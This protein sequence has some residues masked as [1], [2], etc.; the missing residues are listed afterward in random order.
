[1]IIELTGIPGAGKSTVLKSLKNLRDSEGFIFDIQNYILSRTF[2]PFHGKIGYEFVL[3]TKI[4]LLKSEDWLLLKYVFLLIKNS[5]N[6]FFHKVN[7]VRNTMKKLIIYRYIKDSNTVFFI[8]EGVSHIPFTVFVDIYKSMN[9]EKLKVLLELLPSVDFLLIIDAPDAI[10][11]ERVIERGKEGHRRIDFNSKE[12]VE[13]FMQQSR[14][15][16]ELLKMHFSGY[17]YYNIEKEIDREE[18][19]NQLGLKNV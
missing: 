4:F 1:M 16:L 18:I 6:S 19:M 12:K 13:C 17:V 3:L 8:D 5:G 14:E 10:L 2:L 7:I 11:L 15:V 9:S